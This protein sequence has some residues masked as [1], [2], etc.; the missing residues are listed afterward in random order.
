MP[1]PGPRLLKPITTS[2]TLPAWNVADFCRPDASSSGEL[3]QVSA[4]LEALEQRL[5]SRGLNTN[6]EIDLRLRKA[7]DEIGEGKDFYKYI[8]INDD[9]QVATL[10][11]RDLIGQAL[12]NPFD[13]QLAK[14]R[15]GK[16]PGGG[17][18]VSD[19]IEPNVG[20]V[21]VPDPRLDKLAAIG[22]D[23][24][25]EAQLAKLDGG[26]VPARIAIAHGESYDCWTRDG[27]SAEL[28]A[29]P[30]APRAAPPAPPASGR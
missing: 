29:S 25:F 8:N 26:L 13:R 14:A 2:G 4:R 15:L 7:I 27:V 28:R 1:A 19:R 20:Q 21:A 16:Y 18:A 30:R 12:E 9:L 22:F 23:A 5:T 17:H 10:G 24:F 3:R 6:E 11:R